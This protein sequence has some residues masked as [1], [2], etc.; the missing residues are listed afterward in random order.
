MTS[1]KWMSKN[2]KYREKLNNK[3]NREKSLWMPSFLIDKQ[4]QPKPLFHPSHVPCH[5]QPARVYNLILIISIPAVSITQSS[6]HILA[7]KNMSHVPN[8]PRVLFCVCC[9][10]KSGGWWKVT[11]DAMRCDALPCSDIYSARSKQRTQKNAEKATQTLP[12][13]KKKNS[14]SQ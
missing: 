6:F 8:K 11:Q 1:D 12:K 14:L 10:S 13:K 2:G 3:Y 9:S 4:M 7:H 5:V